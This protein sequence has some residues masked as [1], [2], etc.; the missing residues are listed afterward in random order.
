MLLPRL[1]FIHLEVLKVINKAL[2]D[3]LGIKSH[4]RVVFGTRCSVALYWK[5]T[6]VHCLICVD[7]QELFLPFG[8]DHALVWRQALPW[9]RIVPLNS[10]FFCSDICASELALKWV[11]PLLPKSLQHFSRSAFRWTLFFKEPSASLDRIN[12]ALQICFLL[13]RC[14]YSFFLGFF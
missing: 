10:R 2:W 4:A 7:L 8:T 14:C 11:Y 13:R 12:L 1:L 3:V 6:V 9:L 5:S